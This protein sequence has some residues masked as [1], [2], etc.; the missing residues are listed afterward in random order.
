MGHQL[1]DCRK[2]KNLQ[3]KHAQAY[4]T[5]VDEVSDGVADIDLCRVISE[6]N[7][8]GNSKKWWV[9]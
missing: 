1:K 4:I 8:V 3:K 9:D 7:M 5:E 2:S 6:C